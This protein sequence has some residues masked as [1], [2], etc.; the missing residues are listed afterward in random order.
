MVIS[1][2]AVL[3]IPQAIL[4]VKCII[5]T[6]II[7][8]AIIPVSLEGGNNVTSGLVSPLK[9][10]RI[11]LEITQA[12]LARIAGVS[13]T[14]VSDVEIGMSELGDRLERFLDEIGKDVA[15][16]KARQKAFMKE[17]A[18]ALKREVLTRVAEAATAG[19][20]KTR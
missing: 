20:R 7:I 8:L 6:T 9:N 12:C 3:S 4:S 13:Q 19:E 14:H 11:K 1:R 15:A 10:L 5:T 16:S 17:K 18:N 2:F